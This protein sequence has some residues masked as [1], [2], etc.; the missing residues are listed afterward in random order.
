MKTT[1]KLSLAAVALGF[2]ATA[3]AFADDPQLP[4]RLDVQRNQVPGSRQATTVA[5]YTDRRSPRETTI[6]FSEQ[7]RPSGRVEYPERGE[8]RWKEVSTPQ[9]GT[10]TYAA[11]AN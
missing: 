4:N 11:P 9:G 5:V 3:A 2:V 6:A 1:T 7:R 8:V 10:I